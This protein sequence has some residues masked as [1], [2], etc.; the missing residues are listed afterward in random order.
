MSGHQLFTKDDPDPQPSAKKRY[1]AS[2]DFD[3]THF[4]YRRKL[5]PINFSVDS[6][7]FV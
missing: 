4:C 5:F 6:T 3:P 1:L 2:P 7:I